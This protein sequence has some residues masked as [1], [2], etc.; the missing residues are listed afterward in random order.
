MDAGTAAPNKSLLSI[1][2]AQPKALPKG[3]DLVKA[4]EAA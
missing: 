3:L 1:Q 4:R 2:G